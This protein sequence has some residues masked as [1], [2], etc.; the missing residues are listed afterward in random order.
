MDQNAS[1]PT[2]PVANLVSAQDEVVVRTAWSTL[3]RRR[4]VY[5]EEV[6]RL[7]E[8]GLEVLRDGGPSGAARVSDIVAAAQVSRETFYRHFPSKD[9]LVA[10][11]VET[12]ARRLVEYARH[13][14]SKASDP[15]E[16]VRRWATA[17]LAQAGNPAVAR[18]TRA[19]VGVGGQL[20]GLPRPGVMAAMD[21]LA[22]LLLEPLC[23]LRSRDPARDATTMCG[24]AVGRMQ[25]FLSEG[26]TPSAED[27]DHLVRFLLAAVDRS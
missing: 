6:R 27:V 7:L 2:L 8:A 19:V 18:T 14:M 17:I 13:Q 24:A 16:Q 12:G 1:L 26:G 23:A 3:A 25:R 9:D 10:A 11:I 20:R 22:D 5:E 21:A 15:E 4:A